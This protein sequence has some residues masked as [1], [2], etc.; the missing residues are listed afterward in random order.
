MSPAAAQGA[1][2]MFFQKKSEKMPETIIY[3]E[4]KTAGEVLDK[5][6]ELY[7][8]NKTSY[9]IREFH[10]SQ[11]V[12]EAGREIN[13]RSHT[14]TKTSLS[15]IVDGAEDISKAHRRAVCS[16]IERRIGAPNIDK[17]NID[18]LEAKVKLV[19]VNEISNRLELYNRRVAFELKSL[20][21]LLGNDITESQNP[22]TIGALEELKWL[23][24]DGKG[25]KKKKVL[26]RAFR[27]AVASERDKLFYIHRHPEQLKMHKCQDEE[28]NARI[29]TLGWAV[30]G[31][32]FVV[33]GR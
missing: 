17:A 26:G 14:V 31:L 19:S 6:L 12:D 18:K 3:D 16:D 22:A 30:G 10:P 23:Y 7:A 24:N 21:S 25:R 29:E 1:A 32:E 15:M 27:H 9:T 13:C 2:T 33:S 11:C 5:I 28:L 4:K 20:R 8:K